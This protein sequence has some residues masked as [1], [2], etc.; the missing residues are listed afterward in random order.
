M[1]QRKEHSKS[2]EH[3]SQIARLDT[4]PRVLILSASVGAG[5]TRAALAVERALR[6]LHPAAE[7]RNFDVLTLT[8]S[9]FRW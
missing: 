6:Q 7:V 5:H 1:T 3:T 4:A 9:A 2:L 8:N